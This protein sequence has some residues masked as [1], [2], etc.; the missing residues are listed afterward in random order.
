ME[1]PVEA[2]YDDDGK[3]EGNGSKSCEDILIIEGNVGDLREEV[4]FVLR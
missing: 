4:V 2:N 3:T 1:L